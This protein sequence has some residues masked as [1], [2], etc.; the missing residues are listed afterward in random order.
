M[1]KSLYFLLWIGLVAAFAVYESSLMIRFDFAE[2]NETGTEALC[3]LLML[4]ISLIAILFSKTGFT[5]GR[6]IPHSLCLLI[7]W[8]WV[9]S[10]LFSLLYPFSRVTYGVILL[11]L[12]LYF[13]LKMTVGKEIERKWVVWG[14]TL[15]FVYMIYN[16]FGVTNLETERRNSASYFVI[17]S[18]PFMLCHEQKILRYLAMMAAL[19]C[20]LF[21][22]K[23][24]G[25]LGILLAIFVYLYTSQKIKKEAH[26]KYVYI[27]FA[28]LIAL[29]V[30]RLISFVNESVLNGFLLE[31]ID[32][33][34]DTGGSGRLEIYAYFIRMI[35]NSNPIEFLIGRGWLGSERAN[36]L[37]HITCHNDYLESF[38]DFGVV[39]F[40]FFI[41]LIFSLLKLG[42][43]MLKVKHIYAPAMWASVVIF[44]V[45][46]FVS[47]VFYYMWFF[48]FFALFW[49]FIS[50]SEKDA[51]LC[52]Q[53]TRN[54]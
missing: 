27:G 45:C 36:T 53:N 1:K 6:G 17:Y 16:F 20:S 48:L 49:G 25:V 19:V 23:V 42:K 30:Y 39:G 32:D 2:D 38:V 15:V 31:H 5:I 8:V 10:V 52:L 47:H 50:A 3:V 21:S 35:F 29:G 37:E 24:G 4:A 7:M 11:P 26:V 14:M 41:T 18:A 12:F 46:S 13:F 9:I 34:Q 22:M 28:L 54:S 33:V 51:S 40:S 43:K 44:I